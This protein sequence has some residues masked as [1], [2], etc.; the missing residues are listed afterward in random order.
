MKQWI[1]SCVVGLVLCGASMEAQAVSVSLDF[2]L[3]TVGIQDQ[4]TVVLGGTVTAN[5]VITDL[6]D[7]LQSFQFDLDFNS[8]VVSAN[9]PVDTGTFIQIIPADVSAPDVNVSGLFLGFPGPTGDGVLASINFSTHNLGMSDLILND[10]TLIGASAPGVVFPIS[11]VTLQK[12][13]ITVTNVPEPGA[14]VL[15]ATGLGGLL[16]GR[17]FFKVNSTG[18]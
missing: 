12:G 13:T 1:M 15:F 5:V 14:I 7:F 17:R 2:D 8:L 16:L 9:S 10:V 18:Q 11:P 3:G 6:T 4:A